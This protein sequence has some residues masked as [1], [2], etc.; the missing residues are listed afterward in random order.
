MKYSSV[1]MKLSSSGSGN[2]RLK[3]Y[4]C[5]LCEGANMLQMS[6]SVSKYNVT[7]LS[8]NDFILAG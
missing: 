8:E 4:A 6:F 1:Q 5:R 7:Q 2:A 3:H